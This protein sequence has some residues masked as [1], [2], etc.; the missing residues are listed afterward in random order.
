MDS[1]TTTDA[2]KVVPPV[3][4]VAASHLGLT[5]P[6]L[7]SDLTLIYLTCTLIQVAWRFYKFLR[8]EWRK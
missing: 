2:V 6:E 4:V 3:A 7:V 1:Q 8:D 5:V